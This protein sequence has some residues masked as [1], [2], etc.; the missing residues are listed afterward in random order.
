MSTENPLDGLR[1]TPLLSFEEAC[2][3]AQAD[4]EL[5]DVSLDHSLPLALRAAKQM[6]EMNPTPNLNEDEIAAIFFSTLDTPFFSILNSCLRQ[7]SHQR[8]QP[9]FP[10]I[11]LLLTALKKLPP[12]TATVY[13]GVNRDLSSMLSRG[14]SL[15]WWSFVSTSTSYH[16]ANSCLVQ[17]GERTI[18][19]IAIKDG[20]EISKFSAFSAEQEI[21]LLPGSCFEI[22]EIGYSAPGLCTVQLEQ[23]D[24]PNLSDNDQP[25]QLEPLPSSPSIQSQTGFSLFSPFS[26][27]FPFHFLSFLTMSDTEKGE[28]LYHAIE[29][30]RKT[31]KAIQ[32][33]QDPLTDVNWSHLINRGETPLIRA[34]MRKNLPVVKSLMAREDILPNKP[35]NGGST[36]MREAAIE[37]EDIVEILASDPRV[38]VNQPN[39]YQSTPLWRACCYGKTLCVKMLLASSK[40]LDSR[41]GDI[42]HN[43]TPAQE[44]TRQGYDHIA[45]LIDQYESNPEETVIELR[46]EFNIQSIFSFLLLFPFSLFPFS[47]PCK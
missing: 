24:L 14:Q 38:D 10:Y 40:T 20:V 27:S 43:T 1:E 12:V 41:T 6:T 45:E 2:K 30:E 44:A 46:K 16:A 34:C 25:D 3:K 35:S 4:S 8:L 28:K 42:F 32:L 37:R 13:R 19:L 29:E 39:Q 22:K 9:F 23:V 11:K 26:F 7:T 36:A 31:E 33:I 15:I 18:F 21:Y 5:A 47:F 17:G